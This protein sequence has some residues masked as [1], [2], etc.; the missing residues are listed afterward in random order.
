MIFQMLVSCVVEAAEEV[1][2]ERTVGA[3]VSAFPLLCLRLLLPPLAQVGH[4]VLAT[5]CLFI[6]DSYNKGE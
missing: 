3:V 4:P 6:L 5:L 2:V 1:E